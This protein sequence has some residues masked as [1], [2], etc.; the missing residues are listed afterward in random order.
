MLW[1][2]EYDF[3]ENLQIIPNRI[4][5]DM[6]T[7]GPTESQLRL[8]WKYLLQ[9]ISSICLIGFNLTWTTPPSFQRSLVQL[10]NCLDSFIYIYVCMCIFVH[11]FMLSFLFG[12][13]SLPPYITHLIRHK[14]LSIWGYFFFKLANF[15]ASLGVPYPAGFDQIIKT[16]FRRMFRVF[17][18]IYC[19]HF[20]KF[21]EQKEE[22]HL[23]SCF[24][25]FWFIF[26]LNYCRWS[27]FYLLT[28]FFF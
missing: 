12:I 17:A 23:N 8:R 15:I 18:H 28:F 9:N 11:S 21:V 13:P 25:V 5:T 6:N 14:Y 20:E 4:A 24:K 1:W 26:H 7:I 2:Y 16:I 10:C 27:T 22:A 3:S 19:N